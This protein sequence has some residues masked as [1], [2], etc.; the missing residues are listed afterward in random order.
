MGYELV[1]LDAK[2]RGCLYSPSNC[3]AG[4]S[5]KQSLELCLGAD[6]RVEPLDADFM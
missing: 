3:A 2:T 6:I 4:V 1:E 5:C